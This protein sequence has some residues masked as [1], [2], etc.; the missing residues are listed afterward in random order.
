MYF[1]KKIYFV[2]LIKGTCKSFLVETIDDPEPVEPYEAPV[3]PYQ[4]PVEPY[5]APAVPYGA[6][7]S[8][9]AP[10]GK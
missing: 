2:S 5:E 10:K 3:E 7:A 1:K 8:T 9:A 6:D 4:A